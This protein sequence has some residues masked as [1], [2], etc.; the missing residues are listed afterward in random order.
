M[1]K[2][3]TL[4]TA[5]L[6]FG[7]MTV[8][9]ATDY[10]VAHNG[11]L[12]GQSWSNNKEIMTD[13]GNGEYYRTYFAVP[14]GSSIQF[15]VTNGTW[16]NALGS[17][18]KDNDKSDV[19]LSGS[20]NIEFTNSALQNITIWTN[21]TKVWVKVNDPIIKKLVLNGTKVMFYYGSPKDWGN[22]T[23]YFSSSNKKPNASGAVYE[24]G[25]SHEWKSNY[26][27][28]VGLYALNSSTT[29]YLSNN[30]DWAGN[31]KS[32]LTAGC[33]ADMND[34]VTSNSNFV[35]TL[36]STSYAITEGTASA[37]ITSTVSGKSGLGLN[38]SLDHYYYS[39]DGTTWNEL[40]SDLSDLAVGSYTVRALATDGHIYMRSTNYATLTVS[41]YVPG[42][43]DITATAATKW[44]YG[45][46]PASQTTGETVEFTV[47]PDAGYSV[48]V[49][50]SDAVITK[51]GNTYS[52]TMP[53]KDVAISVVATA[54]SYNITYPASPSHYTLA[55]GNPTSGNTDAAINFT[56]TPDAHYVLTVTANG[57]ELTGVSNVYSFTMPAH[58]VTIAVTAQVYRS[59]D[60]STPLYL[61]AAAIDWWCNDN[62]VQHATF[63]KEDN[64]EVVV[65]GVVEEGKIYAFIPGT[66]YYKS[67][68]FSRHDPANVST[69][70]GH[71]DYITL[72]GTEAHD[73]VTAFA[74]NASTATWST[75]VPTPSY[76][77]TAG[78]KIYY[79]FTAYKNG[80]DM[81]PGGN[82]T[83]YGNT[84]EV[85]EFELAADWKVNENTTL[86]QSE[87]SGWQPVKCTTLPTAGQNMIVS[88]DGSTYSWSTYVPPVI[89]TVDFVSL[90]NTIASGMT[91]KFSATSTNVENP[92]YKFYVKKGSGDYGVAVTSFNFDDDSEKYTVKV[93]V[94]GDE[95]KHA[96]AT[97]EVTVLDGAHTIY[98]IN[99]AAWAQ[100]YAHMWGASPGTEWPGDTMTLT[101]SV[102]EKNRYTVYAV[103]FTPNY[104]NIK[105]NNGFGLETGDLTIDFA[106]PYYYNGQWYATLEEC[107]PI[108]VTLSGLENRYLVGE[109]AT[110][111]SSSN[112]TNASYSYEVKIDEGE[113]V[114]LE[115]NPYTFAVAGEY[116]FKVTATGDEGSKSV[117]QTVNVYNPLTLY[118]VN[119]ES[120]ATPYIYIFTTDYYKAW[121]GDAMTLTEAKTEKN[122]YAVYTY[123]FP[124]NLYSKVIFSNNGE[125]QTADLDI[126]PSTPYRYNGEWF[127]TLAECDPNQ[128]AD[129]TNVAATILQ[130]TNIEFAATS[131]NITNPAY[132][133]YVKADGGEYGDAVTA[134]NFDALGKFVVKVEATGDN[135]ESAIVREK[136]VEVYATRTYHNGEV[137][138]VDF[139][140]VSGD[141]KGV[142]FPYNN[143][144]ESLNHDANGAGTIK[145]ITFNTDVTWSTLQDFIKTEKDGWNAQKFTL[146]NGYQNIV[147]VAAD[148]ASYYWTL[149]PAVNITNLNDAY[150][151]GQQV[152]ITATTN[153]TNPSYSYQLKIDEGEFATLEDNPYT[154]AATGEYTF[155]VTV[156]GDEGEMAATKTVNVYNPLTLYF[157]NKEDW[158]NVNLYLFDPSA[159]SAW[160]GDPMTLVPATT[161][162]RHH[163][164]VYSMVVPNGAYAQAIFN[165]GTAQTGDMTIDPD[166]PYYYDGEWYATLEECDQ[167]VTKI[168]L[169]GSIMGWDAPNAYRFMKENED[170]KEASVTVN[171]TEYSDISFKLVDNG[172]WRGCNP[173]KTITKDDNTVTIL[174]DASGENVLMTPYA[175]GDYIFTIDLD[176]ESD[177]YRQITVTYP[178]GEAMPIPQN[179]YLACDVLNEWAP[180][181]PDYKFTVDEGLATLEVTLAENT[182]YAFKLVHNGS[183]YGANY[184]F[185]Y[186][187]NTDVQMVYEATQA[188]LNAFKAGTYTFEYTISTNT[189]TIHFKETDAT[190]VAISQYEYATLYSA[191]GFDVPNE[192]EAYIITGLDGIHLTTE[193][194]YRIP[195]NTGVLLHAPQGNY[196]FYEGDS[197]YMGVD[198][199]ANMMK[200]TVADQEI[201]NELV[202]YILSLNSENVV[203]LYWPY[204][205]GANYGVGSFENKAG[206]A[207]L[208]I[209][210]ASQPQSVVARRGFPLSPGAG[211]PTG[212]EMTNDQLQ[213]TNKRI[214]N[215]QLYIILDGAT[216]N[217]QGTRVQ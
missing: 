66:G 149:E 55:A 84:S 48:E 214:V 19:T 203:G 209:P 27:S 62:A 18:K 11:N 122:E 42:A 58:D 143:T 184:N 70:W 109:N 204:G 73:Y 77:F 213:I 216:Y 52:F 114:E 23:M 28:A 103:T 51:N 61:N 82:H 76:I 153:L 124:A 10:Y 37:G 140:D 217:A 38:Y 117:T 211:M 5:L 165:N 112:L 139:S 60:G 43:H 166:K 88:T 170:S 159:K 141:V 81:Y 136:N 115:N 152:S 22:N 181:D 85:K 193:R 80:V 148:G 3:L 41:A 68:K 201:N 208:E 167:P 99:H 187:W 9:Q 116:T 160:P 154:F 185:N 98:F 110:L 191:K 186:Y 94:D 20:D 180:A 86:F 131:T 102:T 178:D 30:N 49:S 128:S 4:F 67:V 156:T 106:K 195:A 13:N 63:V 210:A 177:T 8:V 130:G 142:N 133:Y 127:A 95:S 192:V 150:I 71:T 31:G 2:L 145:T 188:N 198:V 75:F 7:S 108:T 44:T 6:L 53:D 200:G 34:D 194:I 129:F 176:P 111:S 182:D 25:R 161:T 196:D 118:F 164:T 119:K 163:Y 40:P 134:Y 93:E 56:V 168:F 69:D 137:I 14:S 33:F 96:E 215:G 35:C 101:T 183:W 21:G 92:V 120:W 121:P 123:T 151:V 162:E 39:A 91:A 155:K 1:K 207:Y 147:K 171:I 90:G 172:N 16:D 36:G 212:I 135:T 17:S 206:K 158:E 79:D 24:S 15:K 174:A 205:T 87:T 72:I 169:V 65:T 202:H 45:S 146:P 144:S 89:P 105:F 173:Q 12:G 26:Y 100:V 74:Q 54:L 64:S 197:R 190:E 199:S 78:T 47:T 138:K 46:L 132:T 97:K 179:I 107:D 126:A 125:N 104:T 175:A 59:F 57:T 32:G 29:Y 83:Y 189:L 157:V 50:S 113:Y